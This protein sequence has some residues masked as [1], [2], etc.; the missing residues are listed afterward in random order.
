L[1]EVAATDAL[2]QARIW[3]FF[4]HVK[5]EEEKRFPLQNPDQLEKPNQSEI[6]AAATPN[7]DL[8]N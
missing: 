5:I 1:V 7:C 4:L 3:P 6:A 8:A 2:E